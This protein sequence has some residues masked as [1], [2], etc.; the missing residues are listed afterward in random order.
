[1]VD[2]TNDSPPGR[3]RT[4]AGWRRVRRILDAALPLAAGEREALLAERCGGDA[5][6]RREVVSLLAA[7]DA[8]GTFIDEPA[9]A[10]G[11]GVCGEDANGEDAA[12]AAGTRLGPY[13]I[14]RQLGHGGMGAVYLARRA[15]REFEQSVAVK[16][17]KRGMDTD[18]IVRRFRGE[19]QILA[20][21]EHPNVARLIDGGSTGDGRPY[22]V[23]EHVDGKPI[24]RYCDDEGL[25]PADRLRLFLRVCRAVHFAHQNL[26]V[27]RDLKPSNILIADGEPKL[28]DFGIAKLLDREAFPLTVTPTGPGLTPMTPGYASPE[29]ARGGHVTTASDVYSLGVLLY[30]LLTGRRPVPGSGTRGSGASQPVKPSRVRRRLEGDLDTILLKALRE[31]PERRYATV[32]SF[33]GDL[34]R[35]LAGRPVSAR[36]D[37]L[38]YRC[39]KLIGRHKLAFAAALAAVAALLAFT[40]ALWVQRGRILREQRRANEVA[41]FLIDL[42]ETPDPF[43][44]H[45]ERV[46]VREVL[47]VGA[48]NLERELA[49]E[50]EIRAELLWA[51]GRSHMNLA[52]YQEARPLLERSLAL[53]REL[54]GAVHPAVAESLQLL[55]DLDVQGGDYEAAEGRYR[56]AL[57]MRRELFGDGRPEVVESLHGLAVALDLRDERE[58][59]EDA[60]RQAL[61]MARRLGGGHRADALAP[62]L[63]HFAEFLREEDSF[64]EARAVAEEALA[65]LRDVRGEDHPAVALTLNNLALIEKH[66]DPRRAEALLEEAEQIQ[67]RAFARPHAHL[68]LTL[69]NLGRHHHEAQRL[70]EARAR[71]EEAAAIQEEVYRGPHP[72]WATTLDLLAGVQA[73]LGD[74]EAAIERRRKVLDMRREMFGDDHVETARSCNSLAQV[75]ADAGRWAE[76]EVLYQES[77]EIVRARFGVRHRHVAVLLN[78]LGEVAAAR[79]EPG[80]AQRLFAE[81]VAMLRETVAPGSHHLAVALLN[82]GGVRRRQ[83]E[84]EAAEKNL[85][86]ALAIARE[87]WTPASPRTAEIALAYG[88]LLN[89]RGEF[90]AAETTVREALETLRAQPASAGRAALLIEAGELELG[91][92]LL[93][94]GRPEEAEQPLRGARDASS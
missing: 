40:A 33:A 59:A 72:R 75:L 7:Y 15:D 20:S 30:E 25:P 51:L 91:R 2:P 39:G 65:I 60:Y 43:R 85:L 61:A 76:A 80:E 13:R 16:V 64:D 14:E 90:R 35:Y 48:D 37:S 93:G 4:P 83:G 22:L 55:A 89:D 17:L 32:E 70:E 27:H 63:D 9:L 8:A 19:R 24:D 88:A 3:S 38:R 18:E 21:L 53:R 86:E 34:E 73:D 82:L 10:R 29:Q 58:A 44:G 74:L 54:H 66:R 6:L 23:M 12:V 45:G 62:L 87:R 78:N 50:P 84:L 67:R 42:F 5:E 81:S 31:E 46:T 52:L 47:G 77:L 28:L 36:P 69:I 1:M 71:F 68:A 26:V 57:R 41:E 11:E 94:Q 92:S 49:A 56:E 79:G